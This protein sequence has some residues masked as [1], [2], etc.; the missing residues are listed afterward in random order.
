MTAPFKI[1]TMQQ[2]MRAAY[3]GA[4]RGLASQGWRKAVDG[5]ACGWRVADGKGGTLRCA[6]G[7]LIPDSLA[8][9]R[10]GSVSTVLDNPLLIAE[11]LRPW[12]RWC[13]GLEEVLAALQ[14]AHDNAA[15][16]GDMQ[17]RIDAVRV[18]YDLGPVPSLLAV[19]S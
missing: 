6:V 12:A 1:E 2:A 7:W 11:P 15:D 13:S 17:R 3:V 9:G 10:R 16:S 5:I 19:Q 18:K 14:E 8:V 4:Y